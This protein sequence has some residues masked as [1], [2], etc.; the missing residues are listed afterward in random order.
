MNFGDKESPIV[1]GDIPPPSQVD[2]QLVSG[3]FKGIQVCTVT[4]GYT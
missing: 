1:T 2:L 4:V 3:N